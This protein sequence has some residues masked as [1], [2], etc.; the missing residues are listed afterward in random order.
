VIWVLY[1]EEEFLRTERRKALLDELLRDLPRDFA[2]QTLRGKAF[3]PA[4]LTE[5]YEMAF[6]SPYKVILLLE[7]EA[8][9]KAELKALETYFQNPSPTNHLI[10]EFHQEAAPPLPK[11]EG[12]KYESF[13]RMRSKELANWLENRAKAMN[14]HLPPESVSFLIETVGQD[15]RLLHQTLEVLA[16][17]GVELTPTKIA[18]ALGLHPQYNVYRLVDALAEKNHRLVWQI[19]AYMAEDTRSFP[20]ASVL[21]SIQQ[22][23]Q[24]LM[25][26]YATFGKGAKVTPEA[27]Q[28]RLGLRYAFQARPYS[29]AYER[30]TMRE[31]QQACHALYEVDARLKGLIGSRSSESTLLLH[32]A[33]RLLYPKLPTL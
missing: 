29:V 14:L 31:V 28:Q 22:F 33:A 15:L 10:V 9:G 23:Y 20:V 4:R 21:W 25:V 26:L 2:L 24:R 17:S 3:T 7:A 13:S 11:G 5:F 27:I 8:L 6:G 19:L 16:L 1:G 32:L 12:I 30:Y 18:E